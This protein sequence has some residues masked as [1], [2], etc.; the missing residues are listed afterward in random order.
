MITNITF[1]TIVS[2]F[3]RKNIK[4]KIEKVDQT[5]HELIHP[6]FIMDKSEETVNKDAKK[7]ML[8]HM[9]SN[10]NDTLFI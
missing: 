2:F 8:F 3:S 5:V 9:Y 7:S 1:R 6:R 4:N 10:E